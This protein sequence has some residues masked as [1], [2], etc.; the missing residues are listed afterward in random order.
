MTPYSREKSS[1]TPPYSREMF[2][3]AIYSRENTTLYKCHVSNIISLGNWAFS[4]EEHMKAG[5]CGCR[6]GNAGSPLERVIVE[7][8]KCWIEVSVNDNPSKEYIII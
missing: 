7:Y 1:V 3:D 5:Q 6:P 8:E 2:C 4:C